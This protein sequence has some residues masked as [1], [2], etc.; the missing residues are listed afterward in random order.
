MHKGNFG[1]LS[2]MIIMIIGSC[3][4]QSGKKQ[5]ITI[6]GAFALYP[7]TVKWAEIYMK[8]QPSVQIDVSAGGAGKGM[9][10]VLSGMVDIAMVS[11]EIEV[12]ESEQ[13]A[14]RIAVA[15]DAVVPVFNSSNP[16]KK[17]IL[18]HGIDSAKLSRIFISGELTKW[19]E[20]GIVAP[21]SQ[22]IHL[23]TRSDACGAAS[24]WASFFGKKQEDLQGTGVFG[25]PGIADAVKNDV[26]GLGYNNIVYIY[27]LQTGK[28]IEGLDILPIDLNAN[29]KIDQDEDFYGS[30]DR[31]MDAIKAQ[32]YPSPPARDLYFITSGRP[33]NKTI[34]DFLNWVLTSGQ[35]LVEETGY[36]KLT[37]NQI[38]S[39]LKKL[40]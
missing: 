10:D 40:E 29:D 23:F 32:K 39:E 22:E 15:R 35:Q 9:T 14:F 11:R 34:L 33:T 2:F 26:L 28:K 25:D 31:L 12:T 21:G 27:E 7:I 8:E 5:K 19:N 4:M 18:E 13:G 38:Q 30:L 24:M 1:F 3:A 36:V 16:Y 17:E 6:S 20:L 37:D